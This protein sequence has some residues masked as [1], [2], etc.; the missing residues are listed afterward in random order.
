MSLRSAT[1]AVLVDAQV[2]ENRSRATLDLTEV[3]VPLVTHGLYRPLRILSKGLFGGP[4]SQFATYSGTTPSLAASAHHSLLETG[5]TPTSRTA[6]PIFGRTAR[7]SLSWRVA[8]EPGKHLH[9]E[10]LPQVQP[11]QRH[12]GKAGRKTLG[13]HAAEP[14]GFVLV[15]PLVPHQNLPRNVFGALAIAKVVTANVRERTIESS[16]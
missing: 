1:G 10:D 7:V 2:H 3:K 12:L 13:R 14:R 4:L 6:H 5:T 9:L 15:K 8:G 11:G 16:R